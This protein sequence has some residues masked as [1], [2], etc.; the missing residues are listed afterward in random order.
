MS[1]LKKSSLLILAAMTTLMSCG[2][3]QSDN[4]SADEQKKETNAEQTD[5]ATTD[6]KT[7]SKALG[8]FIGRNLNTP[9]ISFD[10]DS[11][12]TGIRDG[13]SGKPAPMNDKDYEK[14]MTQLQQQAFNAIATKNLEAAEKFMKENVGAKGVVEVVPGKLQYTILEEGKGAAVP[15]HGTPMIKYTGKYIDGTVF[16]TSD[17]AGGAISVPVDNTIPG[18][19][20]GIVGMKEGEKRRLFVHPEMGYGTTGQLPPNSLL[21][22]D[23]EVVK[24]TSPDKETADAFQ[25]KMSKEMDEG[26][27]SEKGEDFDEKE[28][29]KQQPEKPAAPDQKTQK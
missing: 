11:V 28:A 22:F 9:G 6:M 3:S 5:N 15:E 14:A 4:L 7:L 23:I 19:S 8:H 25:E 16:G 2:N 18:F 20:K 26:I 24:A 1:I 29:P 21:I 12:V 10:L 17:A 13:A 27:D